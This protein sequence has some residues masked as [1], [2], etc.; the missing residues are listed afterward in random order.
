MIF[1][2]VQYIVD[3]EELFI[4][5]NEVRME[6]KIFLFLEKYKTN[7]SS[8]FK[9][10]KN[11]YNLS[12]KIKVSKELFKIKEKQLFNYFCKEINKLFKKLSSSNY[13]AFIIQK[14]FKEIFSIDLKFYKRRKFKYIVKKTDSNFLIKNKL[15]YQYYEYSKNKNTIFF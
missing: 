6:N 15:S 3:L 12:K 8:F 13:I 1:Q 4:F 11:N 10:L 9:N 2:I 14:N 7:F 5:N